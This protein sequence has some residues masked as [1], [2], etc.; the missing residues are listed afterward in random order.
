MAGGCKLWNHYFTENTFFSKSFIMNIRSLQGHSLFGY[1]L[2][3]SKVRVACWLKIS[4]DCLLG[5]LFRSG[6]TCCDVL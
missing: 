1:L 6:S 2:P 4:A 3:H 5:Q